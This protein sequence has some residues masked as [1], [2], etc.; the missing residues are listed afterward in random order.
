M[1]IN[2]NS[3]THLAISATHNRV[4]Y[5]TAKY[6]RLTTVDVE[7]LVCAYYNDT[8]FQD[9][10]VLIIAQQLGK[11]KENY[12]YKNFIK[13]DKHGYFFSEIKHPKGKG[14]PAKIYKCTNKA[15]EVVDEYF[16]QLNAYMYHIN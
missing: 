10:T 13:L 1:Q 14:K 5:P 16:L 2:K 9:N 6:F 15:M 7:I 11:K 4:L 3:K 8:I 12:L